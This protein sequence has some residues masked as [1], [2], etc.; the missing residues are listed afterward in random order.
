MPRRRN[1]SVRSSMLFVGRSSRRRRLSHSQHPP[2]RLLLRTLP[3]VPHRQLTRSTWDPYILHRRKQSGGVAERRN[4]H[5]RRRELAST[6]VSLVDTVRMSLGTAR[7]SL[8]A[9]PP[10]C[11][12][13]ARSV[14][15]NPRT[16]R[17]GKHAHC[18]RWTTCLLHSGAVGHIPMTFDLLPPDRNHHELSGPETNSEPTCCQN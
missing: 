8:D 18:I 3:A 15:G 12:H 1:A 17:S 13:L 7:S 14:T 16:D 11:I 10:R 2:R 4:S 9:H 6:T 5:D